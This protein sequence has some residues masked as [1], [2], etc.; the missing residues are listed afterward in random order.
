MRKTRINILHLLPL[1]ALSFAIFERPSFAQSANLSCNDMLRQTQSFGS[2]DARQLAY[3]R[4]IEYLCS[5]GQDANQ[6][7]QAQETFALFQQ[8]L[9]PT[10]TFIQPNYAQAPIPKRFTYPFTRGQNPQ[11]PYTDNPNGI[12]SS[13]NQQKPS[14][15]GIPENWPR[16]F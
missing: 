10:T 5:N 11:I 9:A 16:P 15:S 8:S 4:D 6:L 2:N 14:T 3:Q 12:P 13:A 7:Q 1:L